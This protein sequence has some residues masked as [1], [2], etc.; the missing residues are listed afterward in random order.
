MSALEITVVDGSA[1]IFLRGDGFVPGD[2]VVGGPAK[3]AGLGIPHEEPAPPV[4]IRTS[5][6]AGGGGAASLSPEGPLA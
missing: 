6:V 4:V 5:T 1:H 3:P 2:L